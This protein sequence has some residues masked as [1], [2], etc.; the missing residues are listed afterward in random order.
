MNIA[1]NLENAAFYFPDRPAIIEGEGTY[2]FAEFNREANKIAGAL[3]KRGLMPG[4]SVALCAPNSYAWLAVYFGAI[5]AGAVAVTFSHLLSQKELVHI[6]DDCQ[7]K[8][9]YTVDEKRNDLH[10]IRQRA[11]LDCVICDSGDISYPRLADQG[12][13]T[14]KT[15]PRDRREPAAILYTGGTTGTPKGAILSHENL[16]TSI[17]NV[18]HYERSSENDRVLCFLP[19][20]H[21]FA[22][23]HIMNST[24]YSGGGLIVQPSFDLEKTLDAIKRLQITKLYAVPTIYI[25]LLE[26]EDLRDR[27]RSVRYCFS[28]AASMAREVVREWKMRTGLDIFEAYG[29]TESA[30]MVTYNH[31]YRHVVGS[32]GTPVNLVEVQVRDSDGRRLEK[33]SRG[34]ICIRGPNMTSGY[35]NNPQETR[36]AF[37]G[38][39]F[40]S[41]DI[42]VFDEDG[43]LYIVDR[44]KDMVITGGENVYPREVEEVLYT[45]PEVQECAVVGLPDKEYG[46]R[47]T[48]FIV[49]HKGC[50]LKPD[51]IKSTLK[52]QL[53][54]F[55]I[56]K[57]FIIVDELPKNNAGKIL[58]REIRKEFENRNE[59]LRRSG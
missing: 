24:V 45:F 20:N 32:V 18:A 30:S 27:L 16:Q 6:M 14:F 1:T 35:L 55:K 54:P 59:K 56:P 33:G 25:R 9:L 23:V 31:F 29:M 37:W 2:S 17:H 42:G 53:A 36:L 15:L 48:A 5:K 51:V 41:G 12:H 8:F 26:L 46:E 47:V 19:L 44:L 43:Y 50:D 3:I 34:E 52:N 28:A 49:T 7:P 39:W 40:R 11:Y 57:S 10:D 58:K 22:Q 21:V 38:Q 4:D 13:S